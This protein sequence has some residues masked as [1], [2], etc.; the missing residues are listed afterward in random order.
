MLLKEA[1]K[2]VVVS[3]RLTV[4]PIMYGTARDS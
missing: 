4:T 1:R 2:F 3:E